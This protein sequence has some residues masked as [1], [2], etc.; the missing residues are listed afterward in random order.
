MWP[1]HFDV[2][3]TKALLASSVVTFI[4]SSAFLIASYIPSVRSHTFQCLQNY[5]K[6][7]LTTHS[8]TL[9]KNTLYALPSP[10][11]QF[12][13]PSFWPWSPPSGA[14]FSTVKHLILIPFRPGAASIN[15]PLLCVRISVYPLTWVTRTLGRFAR[16]QGSPYM[17]LWLRSCY[18]GSVWCWVLCVGARISMQRGRRGRLERWERKEVLLSWAMFPRPMR[19]ECF[20]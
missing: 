14:T 5:L 13:P 1:Q 11:P 12:F 3:G 15:I 18:L 6:Q 7:K 19:H 10:S 9:N 17:E 2:H 4:L 16:S 20:I 8:W